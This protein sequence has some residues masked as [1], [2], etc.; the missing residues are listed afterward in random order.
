MKVAI[1]HCLIASGYFVQSTEIQRYMR[2]SF[3]IVYLL[4]HEDY[5][6]KTYLEWQFAGHG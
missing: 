2:D 4:L 3:Q 5:L 1:I 6:T